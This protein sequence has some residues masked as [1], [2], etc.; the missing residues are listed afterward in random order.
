MNNT[1]VSC[2]VG[3]F[4]VASRISG[5]AAD[6][7]QWRGPQRNGL[8]QETGLLKQWAKDGPKL[9]WGVKEIGSGYST[10][11]V[12]GERLYLLSNAGME[13]ESVQAL[14]TMDGQRIWVSPLG[15]VGTNIPQMNFSA[16]RS[17]PTVE[18]AFLYALGSDGDLACLE[19]GNGKVRWQKNLKTNF[20]GKPGD[21]AYAE[22]P[23]VDGD[24]VVVEEGVVDVE[25]EHRPV[26]GAR[27]GHA[28]M[29]TADELGSQVSAVDESAEPGPSR[30]GN[31]R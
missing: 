2:L 25:E 1:F 27:L 24:A 18:G 7:P 6:W 16:A 19:V 31:G 5:V 30:C 22:S 8:S 14:S 4:L 29:L 20:G 26:G 12:V 11:A 23:L 17:T 13:S 10:P 28:V 9:L 21:W 15:K 3:F